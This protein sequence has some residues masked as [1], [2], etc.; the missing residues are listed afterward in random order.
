MCVIPIF[1][2]VLIPTGTAVTECR[3][4]KLSCMGR[5]DVQRLY[6]IV[7]DIFGRPDLRALDLT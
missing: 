1:L 5:M 4:A 7:Y 3:M 6:Q 2:Y